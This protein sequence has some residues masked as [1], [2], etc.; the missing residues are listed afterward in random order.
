MAA[1]WRGKTFVEGGP[2]R[3]K[4]SRCKQQTFA[5]FKSDLLLVKPVTLFGCIF[6]MSIGIAPG[7][8]CSSAIHRNECYQFIENKHG[9]LTRFRTKNQFPFF[10]SLIFHPCLYVKLFPKI[11][12]W[13]AMF[14][15]NNRARTDCTSRCQN[16]EV[17]E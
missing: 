3:K 7:M 17:L 13:S 15:C 8:R 16:R 12:T 11:E 9:S 14:T 10:K 6:E 5:D 4:G 2:E 1:M